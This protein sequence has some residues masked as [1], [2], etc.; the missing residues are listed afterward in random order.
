VSGKADGLARAA[1]IALGFSIPISAAAD[2]IL[3][4]LIVLSWLVAA[5]FR[6][7]VQAVRCN[8]AAAIA[9][10][11]LAAQALGALHSI[12]ESHDVLRVLSK[13]ATFL[14]VPIAIVTLVSARDREWALDAL[15]CAIGLT[16]VLSTLRWL[17]VIPEEVPFLKQTDFS[18]SVV[19]KYHLT[20]NLLVAFGAFLFAV[21]A[22]QARTVRMRWAWAAGSGFAALNV[23]L[24]GDGRIGQVVL[25]AL[26][27]Y[28]AFSFRDIRAIATAG[29]LIAAGG[30]VAYVVPG[31]TLHKRSGEAVAEALEWNSGARPGRPSSIGYRLDYYRT[32]ASIIAQHPFF[33]VGTGGFP[34]AY[35]Q[36]VS[37]TP[38]KPTRNPHNEYLLRAVELGAAGV[39]LLL[40]LFAVVWRQA[41]RL[42]TRGATV[43]ARGLVITVAVAGIASS[44][45][46]DH[47]ETL[48]FVWLVGVLF[49]GYRPAPRAA[50]AGALAT[51]RPA[52]PA[53]GESRW[54]ADRYRRH[55]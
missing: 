29:V 18:A 36:A 41:S 46:A 35:E 9:S 55:E 52:P 34:A 50:L 26:L 3:T 16:A 6:E 43:I 8:P 24:M 54:S 25:I 1:F 27:V 31:S 28:F 2:G 12:G 49:A 20:Q 17:G 10:I 4:A 53:P 32:S 15:M 22:R 21:Q 5:R 19:F 51:A 48:L 44:P 37:G 38:L 14:L 39:I 13:A 47:T 33:G 7:T 40:A 45:L 42:A 23:L 30:A 11:W